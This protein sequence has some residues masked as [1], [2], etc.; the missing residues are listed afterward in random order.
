M[1]IYML[2]RIGLLRL[3]PRMIYHPSGGSATHD[4]SCFCG[5]SIKPDDVSSL[6]DGSSDSAHLPNVIA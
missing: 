5:P 6:D 2:R 4:R 3:T 1:S